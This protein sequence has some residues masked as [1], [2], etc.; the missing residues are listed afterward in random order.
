MK[1][2]LQRV[3]S[4]RVTCLDHQASI[5]KGFVVL[6]GFSPTDSIK[7]LEWVLQKIL[8]LKVLGDS[9]K[10]NINEVGGE[11]LVIPQFTLYANVKKGNTPSFSRAA[12]PKFAN[13]LFNV[14]K[15]MCLAKV[16]FCGFGVFG[17][18]M[19]ITLTNEG[20][21]TLLIEKEKVNN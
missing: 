7:E 10:E 1:A 2:V 12:A 13:E 4:A 6:V 14:F 15:E 20:P 17:A 9:N 18:D 19:K 21:F 5:A 8:T 16:K 11:L 3:S